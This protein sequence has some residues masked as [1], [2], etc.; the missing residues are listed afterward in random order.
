MM[1]TN[2]SLKNKVLR[3]GVYLAL[4]QLVGSLLS[5][6]NVLVVARVLGP[7]NYG[8]VAIAS[9]ILIFI[10]WTGKLGL[11]VYLIRQP[12]L[13]EDAAEQVLAFYNTAG[14]ALCLF[15]AL[16][17]PL[18]GWWTGQAVLVPVLWCLV[19]VVWLE[20]IASA[21]IAMMERQLQ[22][23]QVGLVETVAQI[24]NYLI[25]VPLVLLSFSYWGPIVGFI[26]QYALL[27]IMSRACYA[28]SWRWRWQ[29]SFIST[30]LRCGLAYSGSNLI[31]SLRGL[32]LPLLVSRLA[33]LEAAGIIGIA[34]RIADQLGMF[35]IVASRLSI[36]AIARLIEN[37]DAT[38]RAIGRGMVYQGLVVGPPFAIFS[39]CAALVIPLLFGPEWRP[40]VYLFGL[41][42]FARLIDTV[43]N[44]HI[45]ALYAAGRNWE[46][47]KFN[48]WLVGLFWLAACA[49]LPTLGL[50]G[51]GVAEIVALLSYGSIHRSLIRLFGTPSYWDSV[52]LVAATIPALFAGPW[53]PLWVGLSLLVVSYA[54]LFLLRPQVRQ[55]PSELYAAWKARKVEASTGGAGG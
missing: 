32:T 21:S 29:R 43:F 9:G 18:A 4:R 12:G 30:A 10:F 11:D 8:I 39:C 19:P 53:L 50:W 14:L 40:S 25:T 33:G 34:S 51:Y 42:A 36:S 13:P 48:A 47:A 52:W 15:L 22:F 49:C 26:L 46:V 27:A 2:S 35:R 17:A 54:L 23:N 41:I 6:V 45:S 28:V 5:L 7:E 16:V 3:G 38:R 37:P 31:V 20:M 44:I 55:I 1:K 24:A